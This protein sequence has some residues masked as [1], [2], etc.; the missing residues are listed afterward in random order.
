MNLDS[1]CI[2]RATIEIDVIE[3]L[4]FFLHRI[5]NFPYP[6]HYGSFLKKLIFFK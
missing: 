4:F 2:D 6:E 3:F 1:N 5:T